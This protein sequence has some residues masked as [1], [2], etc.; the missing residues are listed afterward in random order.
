MAL[1]ERQ[2]QAAVA[3]ANRLRREC[4]NGDPEADH[5]RADEILLDLLRVIPGLEEV[6]IQYDA[7]T[8]WT[9]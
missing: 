8:K 6:A 2:R 3:A 1:T 9:A 4:H 5:A 7:V